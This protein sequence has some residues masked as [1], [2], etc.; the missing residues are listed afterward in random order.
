MEAE[1]LMASWTVKVVLRIALN[2]DKRRAGF[3]VVTGPGLALD[4][5]LGVGA[6]AS[7]SPFRLC[8]RTSVMAWETRQAGLA[9]AR[10]HRDGIVSLTARLDVTG[11]L[12]FVRKLAWPRAI[13]PFLRFLIVSG[14]N[15]S[16]ESPE[17]KKVVL[18]FARSSVL[19]TPSWIAGL[20]FTLTQ[21]HLST[22][23]LC[24]FF[25]RPHQVWETRDGRCDG[26]TS[27]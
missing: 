12:A 18:R 8:H 9:N 22:P 7:F 15:R 16:A 13:S 23:L 17:A 5:R 19:P 2:I 20:F 24:A 26:C 3:F 25:C 10:H 14:Q 11:S 6:F 4:R 21:F 1:T 27:E